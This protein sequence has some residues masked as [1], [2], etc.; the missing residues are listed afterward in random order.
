MSFAKEDVVESWDAG[1]DS[2]HDAIAT[3]IL[4]LANRP[5]LGW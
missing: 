1:E 4:F 5:R 3:M 2:E